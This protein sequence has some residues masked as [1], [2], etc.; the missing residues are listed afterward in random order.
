MH[1][2]C[3]LKVKRGSGGAKCT[4]SPPKLFGGGTCALL[5]PPLATP[6]APVAY[7]EQKLHGD[8]YNCKL[9]KL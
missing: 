4:V 2:M 9:V 1:E 5:P 8:F 6:L 7:R 3:E